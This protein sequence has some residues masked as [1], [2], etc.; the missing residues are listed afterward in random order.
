MRKSRLDGWDLLGA[1]QLAPQGRH[2]DPH[3]AADAL[4]IPAPACTQVGNEVTTVRELMIQSDVKG[5][6][7]RLRAPCLSFFW[8]NIALR[9]AHKASNNYLKKR[10]PPP[11]LLDYQ[12]VCVNFTIG[13]LVVTVQ[14]LHFYSTCIRIGLSCHPSQSCQPKTSDVLTMS[15]QRPWS[16][17]VA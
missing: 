2:E 3:A 4:L 10:R 7:T 9:T 12:Y 1:K 14:V 17:Y 5:G 8:L 16:L 15:L 13:H 6:L 11:P